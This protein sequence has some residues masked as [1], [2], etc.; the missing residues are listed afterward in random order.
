MCSLQFLQQV[1]YG[2]NL[3]NLIDKTWVR[4]V[5]LDKILYKKF[6]FKK[7]EFLVKTNLKTNKG[8]K[9]KLCLDKCNPKEAKV[10]Y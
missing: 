1:Q 9:D 4:I 7:N 5:Q 6:N 3:K 8:G 10:S 2:N